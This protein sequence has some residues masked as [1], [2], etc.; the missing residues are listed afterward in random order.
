MEGYSF[1]SPKYEKNFEE[2]R[3]KWLAAALIYSGE[4]PDFIRSGA[5]TRICELSDTKRDAFHY[6]YRTKGKDG[7]YA[8]AVSVFLTTSVAD[9]S[10]YIVKITRERSNLKDVFERDEIMAKL[11]AHIHEERDV[12]LIDFRRKRFELLMRLTNAIM[13]IYGRRGRHN[14][15]EF[16]LSPEK[17]A[18]C[19]ILLKWYK[20]GLDKKG[21]N[22]V[23]RD[24][25]RM[26]G[27]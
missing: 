4:D 18:I 23:A 7:Q 11:L 17:C 3:K 13:S 5:I 20:N 6:A 9:E 21:A 12:Y 25:D 1:S 10:E 16:F 2:N 24:I 19:N 15:A 22:L 27:R 8:S 26:L 14:D